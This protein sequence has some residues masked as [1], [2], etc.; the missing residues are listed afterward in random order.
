MTNRNAVPLSLRKA[1]ARS[2]SSIPLSGR[3]NPIAQNRQG[4]SSAGGAR[5]RKR[6][7]GTP[8]G[9]T[10]MLFSVMLSAAQSVSRDCGLRT[11]VVALWS[12]SRLSKTD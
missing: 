3:K 12:I 1:R 6:I 11:K 4:A 8:C 10:E 5:G 7:L 9:T 2:V